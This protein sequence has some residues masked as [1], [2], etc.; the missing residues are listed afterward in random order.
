M[1]SRAPILTRSVPGQVELVANAAD[2][3]R[4]VGAVL[5]ADRRPDAISLRLPSGRGVVPHEA[6]RDAVER[7]ARVDDHDFVWATDAYTVVEAHYAVVGTG[8]VRDRVRDEW[9]TFEDPDEALEFATDVVA[10][11]GEPERYEVVPFR[12]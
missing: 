12:P 2:L 4:L 5:I 1:T 11:A 3:D 10:E 8:T 6:R 9:R 7:L